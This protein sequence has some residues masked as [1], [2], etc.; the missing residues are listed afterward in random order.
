M[1]AEDS[2]L[3]PRRKLYQDVV[4]RL[5]D[6][7]RTQQLAPGTPL[8]SERDLILRTLAAQQGNM[9]RT[10]EVLGVERSNL[11]RKMKAFG[12][13]PAR[14][15][16]EF[17]HPFT[18]EFVSVAVEEDVVLLLHGSRLKQL[19]VRSPEDRLRALRANTTKAA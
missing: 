2:E 5:I 8:P 7:I 19:R 3:I 6:M 1:E 12:I 17:V 13:A 14:F 9:S 15:A 4:D 10:A 16:D 18:P 11:Y